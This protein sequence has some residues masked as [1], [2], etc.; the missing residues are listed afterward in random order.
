[1]DVMNYFTNR[2][3]GLFMLALLAAS[4][5]VRAGDGRTTVP[6]NGTWQIAEGTLEDVP[7]SFDHQVPVPGLADMA[8]PAFE[9]VGTKGADPRRAAFW[10]R[11][12]FA[13]DG[14]VLAV[15]RLKVHK[16]RYGT[17]VYLNGENLG[18]HVGCFTP[19]YF[20]LAGKLKGGGQANELL[21]RVG[22]AHTA[23]GDDV[24]WG[25][26]FE[27]L[28][29][30]PG[31]Y[32]DVELVLSGSPAI[33]N[34]QVVPDVPGRRVR[35]V[36]RVGNPG[37]EGREAVVRCTVREAKTGKAAGAADSRLLAWKAGEPQSVEVVV[38][39]ADC[40]L[41]TPEEPFLY[42]VEVSV[43]AGPVVTDT[44]TTRFGMRSFAFDPQ[45]KLPMLNGKP[46]FLRGTNICID[47]FF[48][49]PLRGDKPW[50]EDWV[51][52]LI[53][54]FRGMHWNSVRYCIGFPPEVWY[55]IADE[56]GLL[57]QDEFPVWG[58]TGSLENLT[59]QYGEWMEE[60]W[61]HPSVVIWD[62]QNET[63]KQD[64][65][66]KA[67]AA[68]RHLDLSNRP[69]DNGW[70]EG[71]SPTDVYETHPYRHIDKNFRMADLAGMAPRPDNAG[72][73]PGNPLANIGG[74]PI[75]VNEY[76]WLWINRD[77]TPCTLPVEYK[78]YQYLLPP[79]P[80]AD[81]Y[82]EAYARALAAK[83]EFWRGGRQLAGVMH[84]C[85]LGYS[86][87][88]GQTSDSLSD[89]EHPAFEPHFVQYVGDAFA[90]VGVM[91]DFWAADCA[92][93]APLKLSVVVINDLASDWHGPVT[94]RLSNE[95]KVLAGM[96]QAG[97]VAAFGRE[98]FTFELKVPDA[99]GQCRLVAEL[100]GAD[101][102]LVR[103]LRDVN[104][105]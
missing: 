95:T 74:R 25:H 19:G 87:S 7:K 43:V 4:A 94:L 47:R 80:N 67:L 57:I 50:R 18:E 2:L 3:P 59:K 102:K 73:F 8:V 100:R 49:D 15:A 46:Y 91:L 10:Y 71:Q 62:A 23:L 29:Y 52:S 31:V 63:P 76:G 22:A 33:D 58:E 14:P 12:T 30:I 89:V 77:G 32:D 13:I 20:E 39:M 41:W 69:W 65:T 54:A 72:K 42:E 40:R 16:A 75:I 61:N 78:S 97:T 1:M 55:R 82:R 88:G 37:A 36:A 103:S 51:R 44:Q 21:I 93:G 45:T 79:N 17:R 86:R 81:Q 99:A 28:R 38:P 68:V 5:D 53:R 35:V 84:F 34:V 27:K 6:L 70:G 105:R 85:G 98:V 90:P 24:P 101:G 96:T 104:V 66:G 11:R 26:D 48:E 92:R 64:I 60:R 9:G 83:T 56:E